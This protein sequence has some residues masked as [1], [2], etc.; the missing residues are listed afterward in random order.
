MSARSMTDAVVAPVEGASL[1]DLRLKHREDRRIS[2]GHLWI[3][4]NEVDNE[5]TPLARFASGALCRV[6]GPPPRFPG[7]PYAPAAGRRRRRRALWRRRRPR[8]VPGLRLRQSTRA[9]LRS[10]S[11]SRS[12]APA[13]QVAVRAPPA[14]R[15]GSARAE[16]PDTL[17][18]TG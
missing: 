7:Y 2:A 8:P 6:V 18:P 11:R 12:R 16:L 15:S 4:S 9:D 1:P 14:G 13:G 17:V 10:H 5:R 3:F